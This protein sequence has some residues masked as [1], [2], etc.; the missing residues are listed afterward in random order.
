VF[1]VR[2]TYA[3]T[4]VASRG[5]LNRSQFLKRAKDRPATVTWFARSGT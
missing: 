4:H 5:E 2:H 1:H 3:L